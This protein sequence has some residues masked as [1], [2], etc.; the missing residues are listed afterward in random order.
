[1]A[2]A[3]VQGSSGGAGKEAAG[4]GASAIARKGG[5][6]FGFGN[7]GADVEAPRRGSARR[8]WRSRQSWFWCAG[9]TR[10]RRSQHRLL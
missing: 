4:L 8:Q 10:A 3:V 1:M 9:R 6:A 2:L 5:G 7:E